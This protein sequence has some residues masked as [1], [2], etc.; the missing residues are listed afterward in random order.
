MDNEKVFTLL[1]NLQEAS[2][3][4]DLSFFK[5]R[6]YLLLPLRGTINISSHCRKVVAI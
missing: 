4:L 1:Y 3:S 5:A 6:H 2:Q